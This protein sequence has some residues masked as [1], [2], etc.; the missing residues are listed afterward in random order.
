M[1]STSSRRRPLLP[2]GRDDRDRQLRHILSDEA[3]AMSRRRERSKP[4]RT[5]WSV[6]FSDQS[7]VAGPR[8]P[9]ELH[10]VAGIGNHLVTGRCRLV[11]TP[12]RSLAQHR[13]EK[14]QVAGT[15]RAA[16]N[17]ALTLVDIANSHRARLPDR[18]P[19]TTP[20][21]ADSRVLD[22]RFAT[23]RTPVALAAPSSDGGRRPTDGT[24]SG[25]EAREVDLPGE[26]R[27]RDEAEH[28]VGLLAVDVVGP[29]CRRRGTATTG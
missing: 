12:D 9:G 21:N 25:V 26:E 5:H 17:V 11:R 19:A 1:S 20:S 18:Y 13:S 24:T 3:M 16:P 14:G 22:R 4:R 27:L 8:P 29:P 28:E 2:T 7:M 10:H 15:R 6:A 23:R